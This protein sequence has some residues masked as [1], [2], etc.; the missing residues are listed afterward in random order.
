MVSISSVTV[1]VECA[2]ALDRRTDLLVLKYAQDL[3]GVDAAV[4][5]RMGRPLLSE[6]PGVADHLVM[7]GGPYIAATNVLFLGVPSLG[8]FTYRDIRSFGTR[9]LS[10]AASEDLWAREICMT[11][12]GVGFGLDEVEAFRAEV[13][14]ILDA[15]NTQAIAPLLERVTILERDPKR[16]ARMTSI[17]HKLKSGTGESG[18]SKPTTQNSWLLNAGLESV[19]FDS[20]ARPH[21]FVAMPFDANFGDLFHYGI[22]PPLRATGMIC[23][24]MD[25][26]SF[27]G[28]VVDMMRKRIRSARLV[29]GDLSSAN[30]NVYLEVGYAWAAGAPTILLCDSRSDPLFDVRGQRYLRY[31]SIRDLEEKLT[32]ELVV[33]LSL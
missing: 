4:V 2:D 12:H 32:K 19:G 29:V 31:T 11:L 24:R 28:D 20:S 33:L 23:E 6:L 15:I 7:S 27:T 10:V 1:Q 3:Y 17:L 26:L 8:T 22:S 5:N 25:E 21:A 14:G 30:P 18:S 16:A 9:A 13:A